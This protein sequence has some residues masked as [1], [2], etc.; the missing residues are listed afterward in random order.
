MQR[1]KPRPPE[2]SEGDEIQSWSGFGRLG[3]IYK[4]GWFKKKQSRKSVQRVVKYLIIRSSKQIFSCKKISYAI[5]FFK[6]T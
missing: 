3:P 2:E 5:F 6:N 4:H 1:L